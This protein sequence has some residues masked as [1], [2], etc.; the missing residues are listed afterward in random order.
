M[1]PELEQ[2]IHDLVV[3]N[4]FPSLEFDPKTFS[5]MEKMDPQEKLELIQQMVSKIQSG[6]FI[7]ESARVLC[8]QGAPAYPQ[9][10]LLLQIIVDKRINYNAKGAVCD[11]LLLL[12]DGF[13]PFFPLMK[14]MLLQELAGPAFQSRRAL[15]NS[16]PSYPLAKL[17]FASAPICL[18]ELLSFCD[19]VDKESVIA[20]KKWYE[21]SIVLGEEGFVGVPNAAQKALFRAQE[22]YTMKAGGVTSQKKPFWKFW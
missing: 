1:K 19:F 11:S 15:K 9:I 6:S 10:P 13:Q 14:E 21:L 8:L 16:L 22:R 5:I 12:Q 18:V 4:R 3:N 20:L 2:E 7:L 17:D